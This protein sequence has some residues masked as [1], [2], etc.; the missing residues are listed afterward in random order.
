MDLEGLYGLKFSPH[1][2][3]SGCDP[4]VMAITEEWGDQPS[5]KTA[6]GLGTFFYLSSP[7]T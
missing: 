1:P 6:A 5:G 4:G 2:V 7:Q 3:A